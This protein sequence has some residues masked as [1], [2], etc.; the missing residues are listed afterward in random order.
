MVDPRRQVVAAV[1][2]GWRGSAAAISAQAVGALAREFGSRPGDLEVSIGPGICGLCYEV[3]PEVARRFGV[4]LPELEGVSRPVRLDL[5]EINRR[6]L[7]EARVN[8]V[9]LHLGAPCTACSA[10]EF[11]SHRRQGPKAGRMLSGIGIKPR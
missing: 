11:H 3:G 7:V 6:Q 5:T 4:W 1:H 10:E 2:A 8:P 9:R